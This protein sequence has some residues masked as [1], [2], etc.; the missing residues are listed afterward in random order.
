MK[1]KYSPCNQKNH[2]TEETLVGRHHCSCCII[3]ANSYK[4]K[5]QERWEFKSCGEEMGP[6]FIFSW[7]PWCLKWRPYR[8]AWSPVPKFS[9]SEPGW[10]GPKNRKPDGLNRDLLLASLSGGS[11]GACRIRTSESMVRLQLLQVRG[12]CCCSHCESLRSEP[13]LTT[14]TLWIVPINQSLALTN[15][16]PWNRYAFSALGHTCRNWVGGD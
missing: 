4:T 12:L 15:L 5:A 9:T 13:S 3:Q 1:I 6:F 14:T 16:G 7:R 2:R 11:F 8:K 10:K